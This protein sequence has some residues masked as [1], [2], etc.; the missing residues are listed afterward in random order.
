MRGLN[1]ERMAIAACGAG[2]AQKAVDIAQDYATQRIQF[3]RPISKFQVIAHKLADM[4]IKAEIARLVTY[5]DR[6][7]A[8]CRL[9]HADGNR[10]RQDRRDRQRFRMRRISAC[11]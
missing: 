10:D 9:R 11:R 5:R 6:R 2:N 8:G 4:R 7:D 1:L 3:D